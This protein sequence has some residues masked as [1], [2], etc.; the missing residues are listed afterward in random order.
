[1]TSKLSNTSFDNYG[2]EEYDSDA[3]QVESNEEPKRTWVFEV[4]E[5]GLKEFDSYLTFKDTNK[6]EYDWYYIKKPLFCHITL[7][8]D[9]TEEEALKI[10]SDRVAQW[11]YERA[12]EGGAV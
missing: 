1:M 10:A 6:I 11:K 4:K 12:Q 2:I 3:V 5:K 8:A 9:A 7:S